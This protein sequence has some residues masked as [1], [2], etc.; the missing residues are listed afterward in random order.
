MYVA[1]MKNGARKRH[2]ATRLME[3]YNLK[4]YCNQ[5]FWFIQEMKLI[6]LQ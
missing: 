4:Y 3:L 5:K 6:D 2:V 1:V